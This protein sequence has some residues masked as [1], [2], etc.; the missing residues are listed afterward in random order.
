MISAPIH[1]G[2]LHTPSR[3]LRLYMPCRNTF[4]KTDD[5]K[6]QRVV[7]VIHY[8]TQLIRF[9]IQW[10]FLQHHR[11]AIRRAGAR[12]HEHA[13]PGNRQ[14]REVTVRACS[15]AQPASSRSFWSP[16][17]DTRPRRP[18]PP[19]E[20]PGPAP[21]SSGGGESTKHSLDVPGR[22]DSSRRGRGPTGCRAALRTLRGPGGR[23]DTTELSIH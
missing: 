18:G 16:L 20:P 1:E 8:R 21:E 22:H 14:L 10:K 23:C 5:P 12:R 7:S 3:G 19:P 17:A 6:K 9:V 4:I 13:A 2:G 11:P 15:T